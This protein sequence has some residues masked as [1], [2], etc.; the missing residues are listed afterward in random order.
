M[1]KIFLL[2]TLGGKITTGCLVFCSATF[3][4]QTNSDGDVKN[5]VLSDNQKYTLDLYPNP[6]TGI[7]SFSGSDVNTRYVHG[8]VYNL[9]G[10]LV[11]KQ[12]IFLENGKGNLKL[13]MEN[14]VYTFYVY[15]ENHKTGIYILTINRQ[16]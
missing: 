6:S 7:V 11:L 3:I 9:N 16:G 12:E 10:E 2:K 5:T 8:E 1:K 4:A 14:G 15:S 13:D